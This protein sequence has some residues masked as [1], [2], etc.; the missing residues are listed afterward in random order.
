MDRRAG[1]GPNIEGPVGP[2]TGT[3]SGLERKG[4]PLI[5]AAA[6]TFSLVGPG[7]AGSSI[8]LGLLARGWRAVG[9]TG[10]AVDAPS[11]RRAVARLGAPPVALDRAGSGSELVVVA[12]PDTV[13]EVAAE[14]IAPNLAPETLVLHLSGARG[15]DALAPIAERRSDVRIGAIHPLQ[16]FAAPDPTRLDGAWA[17]VAG[18]PAVTELAL[19]LGLR[20]F[21]VADEDRPAY[22]ATAVVASNHLVALLGQVERLAAA[23]GVPFEA[24]LPLVRS[25]FDRA[26]T[27][28]PAGA[29]TGPV[30]RGDASTVAAHLGALPPREQD[31]YRALARAALTLST[32]DDAAMAAVLDGVPA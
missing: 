20:P 24:F 18:P 30:S 3:L 26:L 28:G 14:A 12:T 22:H 25:S 5:D 1:D 32:R 16:S 17:A 23:A 6:R 19:D 8:A 10:H 15:L 2:E 4:R 11:T 31:T 13:I 9:V 29:L 7:R 27:C 21:V